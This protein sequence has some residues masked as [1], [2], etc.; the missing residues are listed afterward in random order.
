MRKFISL[1]T[2]TQIAFC[3]ILLHSSTPSTI[4]SYS[5]YFCILVQLGNG[6]CST[7]FLYKQEHVAL[8][9]STL[10]NQKQILFSIFSTVTTVSW[11]HRL[12]DW[13][14]FHD[15][16]LCTLVL[17]AC[18]RMS[19]TCSKPKESLTVAHLTRLAEFC[20]KTA[21]LSDFRHLSLALICFL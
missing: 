3:M 10:F 14:D 18:T 2:D 7:F 16:S 1:I 12:L 20:L 15:G 11:F 21:T 5:N 19:R 4:K 17:N 6:S 9:L 13:A 8:Y